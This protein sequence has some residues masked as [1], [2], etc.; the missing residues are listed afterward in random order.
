MQE[1]SL[2]VF[3]AWFVILIQ[4]SR[5]FI[6]ILICVHCICVQGVAIGTLHV[7]VRADVNEQTM[8][9]SRSS[10][11]KL[12]G[13]PFTIFVCVQGVCEVCFEEAH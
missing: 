7:K 11:S 13:C 2:V 9:V 12:P 8:L 10:I 1:S 3:G 6:C 4:F 5:V